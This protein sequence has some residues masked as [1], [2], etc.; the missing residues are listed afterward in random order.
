MH[1]F[2]H[3]EEQ[4]VATC[5]TCG[6][7][8]C[9]ACAREAA[10]GVTCGGACSELGASSFALLQQSRGALSDARQSL[11]R[12]CQFFIL[13]G[14][15]LCAYAFGGGPRVALLMGVV[16]AVLGFAGYALTRA[17]DPAA[18]DTESGA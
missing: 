10:H 1:C 13:G 7:G 4:A 14:V 18:Q 6:K 8:L 16:S 15:V 2:V 12:T 5:R 3:A 17:K 11:R 9:R